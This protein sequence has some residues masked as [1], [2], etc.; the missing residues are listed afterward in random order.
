M[1]GISKPARAGWFISFSAFVILALSPPSA[2]AFEFPAPGTSVCFSYGS[3][4]YFADVI[5]GI[6]GAELIITTVNETVSADT[7]QDGFSVVRSVQ[8]VQVVDRS[9]NQ[10]WKSEQLKLNS[11]DL[12]NV[13]PGGYFFQGFAS[14]T[15]LY[16]AYAGGFSCYETIFAVE[17]SGSKYIAVV[18]GFLAQSGF[19]EATGTDESRM[20]VWIL[21][22]ETGATVH[23]HTIRARANRFFGGIFLSGIGG[24]DNDQDDE[25]VVAWVFPRPNAG[26]YKIVYEIYNILNG[27]L[28]QRFNTAIKNTLVFE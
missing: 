13:F 7:D 14:T 5:G 21:D 20:N 25:L 24:V 8:T 11:P 6:A 10:Q 12:A 17:A 2:V 4:P 1:Q 26:T 18:A 9:G 28:E 3:G 19:D 15:P 27:N 23:V 16:P 22:A